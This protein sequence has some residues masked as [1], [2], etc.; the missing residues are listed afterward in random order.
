M[1]EENKNINLPEET[2][3]TPTD[4]KKTNSLEG[5]TAPVLDDIDYYTPTPKKDGPKG[6]EAPVLDDMDAFVPNS[7]KKDGPQGVTAP[8]LDDD[9][10]VLNSNKT[11]QKQPAEALAQ[12]D[13][14][15]SS[16][17]ISPTT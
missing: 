5:V 15:D 8:I 13:N 17:D 6:V 9:N 10:Y 16:D 7:S 12:T 2:S 4:S 3:Y 14:T 11:T 1:N